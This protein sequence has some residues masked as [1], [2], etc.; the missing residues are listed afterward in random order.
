TGLPSDGAVLLSD[1]HTAISNGQTLSVS[2]L[3]GLM[4]KPTAGLTGK[5]SNFTY[6]V[7]DPTGLSTTGNETLAIA[8]G[9]SGNSPDG[10]TLLPAMNG[11]LLTREGNWTF[12][13]QTPYG[14]F[15][16][17]LNGFSTGGSGTELL[18][19]N[20]GHVYISNGSAWFEWMDAGSF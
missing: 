20:Q 6:L 19:A 13:T 15:T 17:F 5:S 7:T 8:T 9:A 18:I 2:Q 3:T 11:S 14:T 12:G 4:F 1:G 16:V 10:S